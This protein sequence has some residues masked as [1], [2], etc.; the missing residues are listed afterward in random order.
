M[1]EVIKIS[2]III[3]IFAGC[4]LLIQKF[5]NFREIRVAYHALDF[6]NHFEV[7]KFYDLD[8]FEARKMF[9]ETKKHFIVVGRVEGSNKN[10]DIK[11]TE[12]NFHELRKYDENK[13]AYYEVWY[14]KEVDMIYLKNE[15]AKYL[16]LYKEFIVA[17]MWILSVPAIIFLIKNRRKTIKK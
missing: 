16:S 5:N 6:E 4:T 17:I 13:S 3:L 9:D 2:S 11:L 8:S 7:K 15:D 10:K 14:N 1:K 12:R